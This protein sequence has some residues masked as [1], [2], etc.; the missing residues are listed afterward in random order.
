MGTAIDVRIDPPL[1]A[2]VARA[3]IE[4]WVAVTAAGGAVGFVPPVTA[5]EVRPAAQ[6]SF[7]RVRRGT[8][9]IAV[10]FEGERPLGFGFLRR[11]D[12]VLFAHIG[13]VRSLQVHPDH[14]GRGIGG[15][16]LG[17][18]GGQAHADGLELLHLTVRGGTGRERFYLD[19]GFELAATL[20]ELI[21]LG[22]DDYRDELHLL[23]RL[24]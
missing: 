2:V 17:A 3:L 14:Q 11:R 22:E 9:R 4:I 21:K 7:D 12:G 8:D 13:I 5:E 24:R 1:D 19:H 15:A 23:R 18:L 6:A 16:L 20:P 10:A